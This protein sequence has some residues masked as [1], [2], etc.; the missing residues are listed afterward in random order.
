MEC[1]SGA[2]RG[3]AVSARDLVLSQC[4]AAKLAEG[5]DSAIHTSSLRSTGRVF[6]RGVIAWAL[7][8]IDEQD[9][10]SLHPSEA[11]VARCPGRCAH[12]G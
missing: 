11:K 7:M 6:P 9:V 10:A 2:Y 4:D 12:Q 8:A 1:T 3:E 5:Y